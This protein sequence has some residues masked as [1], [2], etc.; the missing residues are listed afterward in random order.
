MSVIHLRCR[1][2]VWLT[3]YDSKMLKT[4]K[5]WNRWLSTIYVETWNFTDE[6]YFDSFPFRKLVRSVCN[7]FESISMKRW[8]VRVISVKW[9]N[10]TY[11]MIWVQRNV[12]QFRQNRCNS[13][14]FHPNQVKFVPMS[15][16]NRFWWIRTK[17]KSKSEI[18]PMNFIS[19]RFPSK[20]S[21]EAFAINL[22]RFPWNPE[23][24]EWFL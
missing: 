16:W 18:S 5:S 20:G 17:I 24:L 6:F 1:M 21:C 23:E 12:T 10:V 4:W 11:T 19:T 14:R 22:S 8:W 15:Y 7:Q 3:N 13:A 2:D 9:R